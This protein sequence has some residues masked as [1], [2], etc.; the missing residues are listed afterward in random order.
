MGMTREGEKINGCKRHIVTDTLGLLVIV[1]VTAASLQDSDGYRRVLE[2]A[3]RA[4]PSIVL[5]FADGGCAGK[6]LAF[7]QRSMHILVEIVHKPA[8]QSTSEVLPRRWDIES[9][10][11]WLIRTRRLARDYKPRPNTPRP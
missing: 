2:K 9:P 8:G 1:L 11:A 4:L 3:K 7:A 6:L 10:L 5:A